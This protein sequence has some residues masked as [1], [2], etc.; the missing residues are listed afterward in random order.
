MSER[1]I[2][3]FLDFDGVLHGPDVLLRR[4]SPADRRF[5]SDSEKRFVTRNHQRIVAA[6]GEL[7]TH[8]ERLA[9]ALDGRAVDVVISSSWRM[10]FDVRKL[11]S[12]LPLSLAERVAGATPVLDANN[13]DGI[14]VLECQTW[15]NMR[16]FGSAPWLALD[17]MPELFCSGR[18]D[19]PPNLV[20]CEGQ[21]DDAAAANLIR[22]LDAIKDE[23]RDD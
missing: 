12:F 10:H 19:P 5:L 17:D 20:L 18:L 11:A 14:R 15:L 1:T 6:E 21:F 9:Q 23:N 4:C 16:G 2:F 7:F 8:A 13:P 22:K 3:L